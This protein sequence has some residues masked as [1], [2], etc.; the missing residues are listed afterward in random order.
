[1]CLACELDALWFA[2]M[3]S[4]PESRTPGGDT[5]TA[6]DATPA[7]EGSAERSQSPGSDPAAPRPADA[8]GVRPATKSGFICEETPS[9]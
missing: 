7:G 6:A 8:K 9:E 5:S 3:A 2:E 4:R 1:M